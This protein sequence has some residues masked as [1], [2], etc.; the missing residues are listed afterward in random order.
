MK[1]IFKLFVFVLALVMF[2]TTVN[3][4]SY[5]VTLK[6]YDNKSYQN[7]A[8]KE[9]N[10]TS[11][12]SKRIDLDQVFTSASTYYTA[13]S[14]S[15]AQVTTKGTNP[16]K[17]YDFVKYVDENG[18]EIKEGYTNSDL[19]ITGAAYEPNGSRTN[20]LRINLGSQKDLTS[21]LVINVYVE[22][23]EYVSPTFEIIYSDKVSTGSGSW[24][25][26]SGASAFSHKFSDPSIKTP[27]THYNF[28]YWLMEDDGVEDDQIDPTKKYVDGDKFSYTYKDKTS[29]WTKTVKF[30]AWWQPDVTLN[31]YSDGKLISSE[32][33]F[34]S[35]SIGQEPTKYG[36]KFL[37][38]YD[39]EGNEVTETT[40]AAAEAG[41]DPE[42]R[43]YTLYA[44]WER[45][46]V[47]VT[48]TKVWEDNNDEDEI[49]PESVTVELKDGEEV[50][51]TVELSEENKWTYTFNVPKY[52]EESKIEYTV[53]EQEIE[54]YTTEITGSIEEGFVITNTHEVWPK[55]DGEE[56]ELVQTGS[57]LNYSIMTSLFM[58]I[59]LIGLSLISNKRFN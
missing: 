55:G 34:E 59:S 24:K 21:D 4:E 5:K 33:S 29:G 44:K 57:E 46:M 56:K 36:Y 58:V 31:L 15:K 1:K 52:N 47:D 48:V 18:V 12:L 37:G 25:D 14:N 23:K 10:L 9:Y 22:W 20:S 39:A 42:V 3:A 30:N 2:G 38:W 16:T 32:S 11:S 45:I 50:V 17:K 27:K 54:N 13:Y 53:S 26:L 51:E 28:L 19:L 8:V 40:F 6:I 35:V 41:I 7:E 43:E 49:R